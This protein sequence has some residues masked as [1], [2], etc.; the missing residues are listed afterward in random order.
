MSEVN[1]KKKKA[2]KKVA[3]KKAEIAPYRLELLVTVID[4]KK[5]AYYRDTI[6]SFD[7]NLQFYSLAKGTASVEILK[8]F[9][10]TDADKVAIFSVIREDRRNEIMDA[11][12]TKFR[13]IKGGNGISVAIPLS[14]V[15]GKR[16]FGFLSD[17]KRT[18]EDV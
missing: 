17:E 14:S 13:T 12:E 7:V 5:A 1:T 10:L 6:Q 9:G 16:V 18:V 4:K 2:T 11:L 3:E 8:F 15:I